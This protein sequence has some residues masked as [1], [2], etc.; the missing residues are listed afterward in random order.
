LVLST[1]NPVAT[2]FLRF[3]SNCEIEALLAEIFAPA[4]PGP[5]SG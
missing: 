1:A 3:V 5:V 4:E 2:A